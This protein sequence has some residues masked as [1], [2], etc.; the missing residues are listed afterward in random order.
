MLK[1][2]PTAIA[3]KHQ[4]NWSFSS[5]AV[6]HLA[7]FRFALSD[8]REVSLD[9]LADAPDAPPLRGHWL[10]QFG[11]VCHVIAPSPLPG[12]VPVG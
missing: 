1:P 9:R 11:H 4:P 6:F 3:P 2:R 10:Q 8:D 7:R 12:R 5:K